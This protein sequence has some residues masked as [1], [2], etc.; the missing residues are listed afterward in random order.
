MNEVAIKLTG[1]DL[2]ECPVLAVHVQNRTEFIRMIQD[3]PA[4]M[5]HPHGCIIFLDP[6]E[7][8][9]QLDEEQMRKMG[10]VRTLLFDQDSLST[11][12]SIPQSPQE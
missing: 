10:W 2:R 6:D 7:T 8:I 5:K 11:E 9:E 1:L 3:I 4:E 12:C